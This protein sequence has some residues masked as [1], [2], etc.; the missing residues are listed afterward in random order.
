VIRLLCVD[1]HPVV[2]GGLQ[3]FIDLQPDMTVV[4]SA[5][6][7]EEGLALYRLHHPDVTLMDL[8]LPGMS[9]LEAIRTIRNE[10]KDARV[11]VLT[12]YEGDED[13]YRAHEAGATTYLLKDTL[14]SDLIRVVRQVHAGERPVTP[15]VEARL[16]ERASAP[17]LTSREVE[18]LQL[19]SEGL[20][21]KEVGATLG[22]TEGT[23]Q[24]HVKNIFGKLNVND[25]TAA[26]QVA[27]RRG[28][29]QMR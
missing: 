12:M 5:A 28:L 24:I 22:I 18:V 15:V 10:D 21:N 26:V 6:T 19:I 2:R 27:V 7:G 3:Q 13:I 20:R 17:T 16:K 23:V 25:R 8:Q 9:G 29:V 14:S 1:D 4:A 11:I